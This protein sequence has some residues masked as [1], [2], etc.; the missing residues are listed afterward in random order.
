MVIPFSSV[1]AA[2]RFSSFKGR[3]PI[4]QFGGVSDHPVGVTPEQIKHVY[5]LPPTGGHGTIAIIGAYDDKTIENDLAIFSTQFNL[6]SCTSTNGCFEK[7][8]LGKSRDDSGWDMETSLDV[9]WAHAI[10]PLAKILL[11]EAKTPSGSNLLQAIDFARSR[12]GVVAISMS[13]GGAEFADETTL[14]NHFTSNNGAITFFASA[15]DSG[16]GVSWPASSPNVVAVGGTYVVLSKDN[17]FHSETAWA[18]S[19]G[20]ISVYESEPSF[21]KE[22]AITRANG[23]RAIPDVSYNADPRSGFSIYRSNGKSKK[24]WFVVGG[25]SAGAPQWAAIKSLGLSADANK[26][27]ADKAAE[28]NSNYFRDIKSGNNGN[29]GYYCEARKRYDY[30]TGLG[31]PLTSNF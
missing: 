21:Q 20:G 2:Y 27:Y 5:N 31:S 9:E 25:T 11:V 23:H 17:N 13:W 30:V 22:Y 14:D 6:P 7:R 28:N 4:H 3:P 18:G 8:I 26:F 16:T 1:H 19:G 29:C 24:G 12:P 15:G 10:A